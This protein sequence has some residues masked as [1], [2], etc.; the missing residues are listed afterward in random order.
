MQASFLVV[1]IM[2]DCDPVTFQPALLSLTCVP[3]PEGVAVCHV[4]HLST[5]T[6]EPWPAHRLS[7]R[8]VPTRPV[9]HPH[10]TLRACHR[11]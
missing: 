6:L 11:G 1:Q 3:G 2:V 8:P 4:S 7:V 9:R 5:G 10:V